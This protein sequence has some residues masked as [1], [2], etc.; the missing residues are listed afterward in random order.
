MNIV[1]QKAALCFYCDLYTFRDPIF[2]TVR[3]VKPEVS[4]KMRPPCVGS[5]HFIRGPPSCPDRL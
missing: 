5:Q 3:Q 4:S 2:L 1:S